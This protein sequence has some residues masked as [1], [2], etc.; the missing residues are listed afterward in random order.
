MTTE[1]PSDEEPLALKSNLVLG[2]MPPLSVC[3]FCGQPPFA[4]WR[5]SNPW[6]KCKTEGCWGGKSVVISLDVPE[7]VDAWNTRHHAGPIAIMD[8]RTA[9]GL[10]AR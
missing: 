4:V 3:P 9:L 2:P 5:R 7:Q 1:R 6:A 8:T 10:C